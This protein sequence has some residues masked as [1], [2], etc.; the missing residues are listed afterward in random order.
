MTTATRSLRQRLA[1][2]EQRAHQAQTQ[3]RAAREAKTRY[4][5]EVHELRVRAGH[6]DKG[7]PEWRT[8]KAEIEAREQ[9]RVFNTG[10][11]ADAHRQAQAPFHAADAELQ[12]FKRH[13][14]AGLVAEIVAEG[15]GDNTAELTAA[16]ETIVRYCGQYHQTRERVEALVAGVTG[17]NWRDVTWCQH[18]D[19]WRTFAADAL[20]VDITPPQLTAAAE[21]KARNQHD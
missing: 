11:H 8:L 18:I 16:F 13:N 19:P 15:I 10:P 2:L 12:Q 14:L 17:L 20:D 5:A 4:E 3:A 6:T 21:W 9:S 1:D 7:T